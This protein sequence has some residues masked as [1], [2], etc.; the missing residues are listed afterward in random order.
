MSVTNDLMIVHK[1]W[2][3]PCENFL[4][5]ISKMCIRVQGKAQTDSKAEHTR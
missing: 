3:K 1:I 4:E 5:P 2:I